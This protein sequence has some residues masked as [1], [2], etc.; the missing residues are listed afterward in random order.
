MFLW[1]FLVVFSRLN[2]WCFCCRLVCRLIFCDRCSDC[3]VVCSV[4][5]EWWVMVVVSFRVYLLVNVVGWILLISLVCCVWWVL[6]FLLFS[7]IWLVSVLL[8]LWISCWVLLVFGIMLRVIF[9][10]LKWVLLLVII[11]LYSRVS[12]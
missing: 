11:R 2:S 1:W 5:G 7:I 3:F 6:I 9:G 10:R 12:L 4:S 8:M